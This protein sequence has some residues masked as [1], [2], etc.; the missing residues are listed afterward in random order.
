MAPFTPTVDV[1]ELIAFAAI[2][3]GCCGCVPCQEAAVIVPELK[4]PLPSRATMIV[5]AVFA[6]VASG[7]PS[8]MGAD[9]FQ[10][11]PPVR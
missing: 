9:P 4:F 11:E 1:A 6:L 10:Q 7:V 5:D 8:V 3:G 2:G